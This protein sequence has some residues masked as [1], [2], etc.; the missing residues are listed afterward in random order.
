LAL[1]DFEAFIFLLMAL[2]CFIWAVR[3]LLLHSERLVWGDRCIARFAI[4]TIA[5]TTLYAFLAIPVI[6]SVSQHPL[7]IICLK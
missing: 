7:H 4:I 1:A 5:S 2:P 3:R 6:F